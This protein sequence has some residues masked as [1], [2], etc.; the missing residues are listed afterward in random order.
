[1]TKSPHLPQARDNDQPPET[2]PT[3][4]VGYGRPPVHTRVK[5]GQV[6]NPRGRPKGQRN[7]ATV[8]RKALNE[9]TKIREGNRTRSVTK[10]D[11]M[12]LK[13]INDANGNPKVQANLIALMRAVGLVEAPDTSPAQQ[14]PLTVDDPAL[15]ADFVARNRNQLG[16]IEPSE[17]AVP[18]TATEK[19]SSGG[20]PT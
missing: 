6:L 15:I 12:I 8:L 18:S 17:P 14:A 2:A 13:M 16:L 3:Y 20:T 9:R 10:L 4:E 1:M 11:A 19:P 7:V 5:P